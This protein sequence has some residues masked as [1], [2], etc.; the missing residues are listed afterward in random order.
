[1]T[2]PE[3]ALSPDTEIALPDIA[4]PTWEDDETTTTLVLRAAATLA[5]GGYLAWAQY[6][7]GISTTQDWG[8]WIWLSVVANLLF[9]LGVIWLFFGQG[10]VRLDWL[11]DQKHNAWNYG[12]NFRDWRRHLK[13][14][15]LF[16]AVMTVGMLVFR[17]TPG[18]KD[19]AAHYALNYFPPA[20]GLGD[21]LLLLGSLVVYMFCWEFFFRG[22]ML[23]GMAQGFGPVVAIIA[24][25]AI[26]GATHFGKAPAEFVSS[27][28]GGLV[29][30]TYCWKEKSFAPAFYTHGL[31]HLIWAVMVL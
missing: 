26:F 16:A 28:A 6:F 9:P 10:I 20:P 8:R 5:I 3:N 2:A 4:S 30:G 31:V 21:K 7:S 24:Q 22:F 29:L 1:M 19:A 23:F 11:R 13:M 14:A 17:L 15:G 18:G 25:T 27:F 12:W